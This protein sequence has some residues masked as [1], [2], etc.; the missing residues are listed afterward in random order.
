[1]S[2]FP[3]SESLWMPTL[4]HE[5]L[6]QVRYRRPSYLHDAGRMRVCM[7][8]IF[9]CEVFAWWAHLQHLN[10]FEWQHLCMSDSLKREI[11]TVLTHI[12]QLQRLCTWLW[13]LSARY[14]RNKQHLN[15]FEW[16]Y[17][18]M[19]DS[20]MRGQHTLLACMIQMKCGCVFFSELCARYL[21]CEL[22]FNSKINLTDTICTWVSHGSEESRVFLVVCCRC[23]ASVHVWEIKL[24][25]ICIMS[26]FP[27]PHQILLHYWRISSSLTRGMSM[28]L[29]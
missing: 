23:N 10:Q 13:H 11:L 8:L 12:M 2:S 26:W 25:S 9:T 24:P 15:Q 27:A 3:L 6:I 19:N 17:L 4:T 18:C 7:F 22:I 1:M 16:D 29:L 28:L 14:L 20:L 21:L 5:W